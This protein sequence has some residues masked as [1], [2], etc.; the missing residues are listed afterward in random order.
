MLNFVLIDDNAAHHQTL[1][2]Q[3]NQV[4]AQ[5][6]AEVKVALMTT[7]VYD[8]LNYA[9]AAKGTSVYFVDIELKQDITGIELCHRLREICPSD[10]IVYV[11]SY[12]QYALECCRSHAFDFLL[13][14]LLSEQLRDCVAAILRD[15]EF[16][17]HGTMLNILM[18]TKQTTLRQEEIL[19]FHKEVNDLTAVCHEQL[20][21][22]WRESFSALE[23]RISPDFFFRCHRSYI[24][25]RRFIQEYRWDECI[26]LLKNG[27]TVPMSR[28]ECKKRKE[29]EKTVS[30]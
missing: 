28:R 4:C 10:Y 11:S 24:V 12:Q 13:K 17:A 7:D 8:V 9:V 25:N 20:P 2:N 15:I 22:T 3:L 5:L 19:Y 1:T 27:E 23:A 29:Q 16:R 26:I 18:G 30:C 21:I 6:N 14:P